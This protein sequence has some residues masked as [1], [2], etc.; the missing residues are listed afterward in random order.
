[1]ANNTLKY[2]KIKNDIRMEKI[3]IWNKPNFILLYFLLLLVFIFLV[4]IIV[5]IK[6]KDREKI[7]D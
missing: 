7:Y 4:S 3:K 6:I 5:M 1:M 2:K